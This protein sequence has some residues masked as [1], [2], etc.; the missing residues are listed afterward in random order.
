MMTKMHTYKV[1]VMALL[2]LTLLCG[3]LMAVPTAQASTHA[4]PQKVADC[5]TTVLSGWRPYRTQASDT[6][7]ALAAQANLSAAELMKANCLTGTEISADTLLLVP[8]AASSKRNGVLAALV[9]AAAPAVT[10]N[11][12]LTVISTTT[13]MA[14]NSA[15][16]A[17]AA[18]TIS[19]WG[20]PDRGWP[21]LILLALGLVGLA[22]VFIGF[23]PD[24]PDTPPARRWFGL[25]SNLLF[26]GLGIFI[27]MVFIPEL[28]LPALSALP[29]SVSTVVTVAL[30]G[31]LVAKEL[32]FKGR[33]WRA[34]NRVLN[35]GLV[36]LLALFFLTVATRVAETIN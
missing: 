17:S 22:T 23:R 11:T 32:F 21:W 36:P 27:G 34:L 12:L 35:V 31:L 18:T 26:L 3:Q 2:L 8:I 4:S 29:T 5:H 9:P 14:A 28:R 10:G 20:W 7:D 13:T 25:W 30:I 24:Q 16:T 6:L 1:Y 19:Q 15:A 33:Q